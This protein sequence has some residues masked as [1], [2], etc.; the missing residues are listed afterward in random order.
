MHDRH[1]VTVLSHS[2]EFYFLERLKYFSAREPNVYIVKVEESKRLIG[3][4]GTIIN[5]DFMNH[6]DGLKPFH[7]RSGTAEKVSV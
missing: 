2:L 3:L 5:I 7:R 6:S 1:K 4:D